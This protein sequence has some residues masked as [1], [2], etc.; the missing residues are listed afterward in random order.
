MRVLFVYSACENLGIEYLSAVLKAAG[1]DTSLLYDPRLFRNPE[2]I[3]RNRFLARLFHQRK[4]MERRVRDY[5]P[6]LVAFSVVSADYPWACET[7][8]MIRE[9][10]G[11]PTVFGNIHPTAVPKTVIRNDFVDF[12]IVGEGEYALLDLANSLESKQEYFSI[13][14]VWAKRNG[15]IVMNPP[16]P[17]I[18]DLDS[19][20]FPDRELFRKVGPPYDIGLTAIGS[21]GCRN[22][23]SYCSNSLRRKLYSGKG[24]PPHQRYLRKRSV[25]NFIRELKEAKERYDFTLIR[26]NDDDFLGDLEWLEEFSRSYPVEVGVPYKCFVDPGSV[27]ETGLELLKRSGC[28]QVQVGIQSLNPRVRKEVLRRHQTNEQLARTVDLLRESGI[29]F[30]AD[31][32]LGIPGETEQDLE[33]L[34]AFYGEHPG[35]YVNAYWLLYFAGHDIVRIARE[36]GVIDEEHER[37][38]ATNPFPGTHLDR[39]GVHPRRLVK[40]QTMAR[41]LNYFPLFLYRFFVRYRLYRLFPS[42]DFIF[43][44]RMF[45]MLKVPRKNA[46]PDPR[47]VYEV[48]GLR[49][50]EEYLFHI[51][52]RIKDL[53]TFAWLRRK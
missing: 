9:W 34:L 42:V 33:A 3:P 14:N 26:L 5:D 49:R 52:R 7:A 1:H 41:L 29:P 28:G 22:A 11:A 40:Y 23:C 38:L 48:I 18:D 4:L 30:L 45:R 39:P 31:N 35:G 15:G 8:R 47:D 20:P 19:L 37:E 51:F 53:F 50:R 36:R 44:L 46:F 13:P 27:S 16:R 25:Q 6:G 21:R 17:L 32:L 12:V 2:G 43:L 24:F 10:T